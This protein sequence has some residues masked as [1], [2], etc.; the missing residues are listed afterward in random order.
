[1][2]I[3]IQLLGSTSADDRIEVARQGAED[4]IGVRLR[5]GASKG[6]SDIVITA[7]DE[8]SV[9]VTREEGEGT[10]IEVET[11]THRRRHI[12]RA[13][14]PQWVARA[15]SACQRGFAWACAT[16][17][18]AVREACRVCRNSSGYSAN[19]ELS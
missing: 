13:G 6:A 16:A 9:T 12:R 1:M 19:Q 17:A 10:T 18:D 4:S 2:R 11:A 5:R 14:T 15:R 7:G 3:Q 8:D